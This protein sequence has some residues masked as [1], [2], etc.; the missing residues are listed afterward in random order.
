M[1]LTLHLTPE[2]EQRLAQEAKRQGSSVDVYALQL[3]DKHLPSAGHRKELIALLQSWMDEDDAGEQQETG[4]Y[5]V[6]A[7]NQ[8]RL[9]DRKLFPPEYKDITW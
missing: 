3:L 7:L 9:S 4:E 2:L 6:H 5:I 1:T 8:E